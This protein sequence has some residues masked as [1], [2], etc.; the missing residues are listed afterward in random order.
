VS[1]PRFRPDRARVLRAVAVGLVLAVVAGLVGARAVGLD[2]LPDVHSLAS[3]SMSNDLLV[4]DRTGTVLLADISA[5]SGV[6]HYGLPLQQMGRW[7]P[8]ATVADPN[9][10]IAPVPALAQRLIRLRHLAD[11]S[12]TAGK[13]R[14]AALAFRVVTAFSRDQVLA[15]YL[16]SLFYGNQAYG[17]EAAARSYFGVGASQLDLAQAALL[18]G[19]PQHPTLFDPVRNWPAAKERQRQVLDAMARS[20]EITRRQADQA[21]GET[22]RLSQAP[23]ANLAPAFVA[24]ALKQLQSRGG[25]VLSTVAAES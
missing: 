25:A 21:A 7:L 23:S 2:R 5:G 24:Y 17:P 11:Y 6:H 19:V 14:Q 20:G 13:L 18:A 9:Y 12:G 10:W 4:Y 3:L 16:D 8:A 1:E 15:M 22:L